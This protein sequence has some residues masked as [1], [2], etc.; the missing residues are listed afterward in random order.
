MN[1]LG[2][3]AFLGGLVA[4]ALGLVGCG[5][6]PSRSSGI[7][8]SRAT[9]GPRP[10][11]SPSTSTTPS[12]ST[13]PTT[14]G[15]PV[16]SHRA[17]VAAI[18]SLKLV[19]WYPHD[20]GW[21]RL[22]TAATPPEEIADFAAIAALGANA[23]RIIVS[24]YAFGYPT[25]ETTMMK[26]LTGLVDLAAKAN[27]KVQLTLFD[28]FG[29]Y[30]D[31]A[32]S[33]AWMETVVAPFKNDPRICFLELKNEV[34]PTDA[35]AVAWVNKLCPATK[36]TIG[37]TPVTVSVTSAVGTAALQ[38]WVHEMDRAKDIDFF[39]FHWY[40]EEAQAATDLAAMK[41]LTGDNVLFIGET[42]SSTYPVGGE[43]R[44]QAEAAQASFFGV[45]I[46]SCRSLGLPLPA[47]WVWRDFTTAALPD[48]G[49]SV[50]QLYY[51]LLRLD[52]SRK[53]SYRIVQRAFA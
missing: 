2:R 12:T 8:R 11:G 26:K 52:G 9:G 48:V 41:G 40:G 19:N 43:N 44:S 27:L 34:D 49:N 31:I 50:S 47:P 30:R 46:D 5:V 15:R 28:F 1:R 13:P 37:S 24:T 36:A 14:A 20:A 22:W 23:V 17:E 7:G 3:R 53:P 29:D 18:A 33:L 6:A 38:S 35:S 39:D 21:A 42:G 16:R 4:G 51:G 32:G 10:T 25:P 45:V